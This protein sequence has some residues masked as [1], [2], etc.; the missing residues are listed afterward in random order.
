MTDRRLTPATPRV[1]HVSLQGRIAAPAYTEGDS[2]RVALPVADLLRDPGGA[3]ERQLLLGESF[4]V[5]ERA[6]GHAFGF[7]VKDG[8]CGWLAEAALADTARPT[9]WVAVPA[10]HLYPEPRVQ[11]RELAAL[12]LGARLSVVHLG[13][14]WAETTQGFVPAC[15]LRALGDWHDD[16]VAVAESLLGTPYLWGGNSRAGIDC[17]GL[18]QLAHAA[19]GIGLP[20]DSDLQE[21]AGEA[22]EPE[23]PL[24]RGD[25]VFWAGHVALVVDGARLI[26]A[27][28]QTMSVAHEDTAACLA[29]IA[30][31]EGRQPRARRR[32]VSP[33]V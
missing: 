12:S 20:G 4:T 14:K 18:V 30:A 32:L 28:G 25:L 26:H 8:Y 17:S 5:I 31:Q 1:A 27:N 33:R 13:D 21:A 16:P 7:A 29:R 9:H 11:A 3:R 19:C 6:E 22:V 23:A 2:L 24:V 10:S 15:H